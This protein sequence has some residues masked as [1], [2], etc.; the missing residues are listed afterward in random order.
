M[1]KCRPDAAFPLQRHIM[2]PYPFKN[3]T[4]EQRIF[5]Y[6][7]SRGRRVV[8]NS[9]GIIANRFRI[10]LHPINFSRDKVVAI[11]KACYVLHKFLLE[12]SHQSTIRDCDVGFED[13]YIQ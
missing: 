4:R 9:F 8:K 7:L 13:G 3:M 2:K 11:T 5:N 10:L 1:G 6:R 12:Q